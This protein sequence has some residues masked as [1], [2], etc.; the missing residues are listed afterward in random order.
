MP[1]SSW[2]RRFEDER[3]RRYTELRAVVGQQLDLLA[4]GLNQLREEVQGGQLL[5]RQEYQRE[6][7]ALIEKMETALEPLKTFVAAQT[8][9]RVGSLDARTILFSIVGGLIAIAAVVS[10][11]IH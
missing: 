2:Q 11:H 8:G 1:A 4:L 9:R 5:S 3:D 10:P 6:H 7:Q